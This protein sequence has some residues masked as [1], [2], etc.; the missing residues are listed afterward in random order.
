MDTA[1]RDKLQRTIALLGEEK[2]AKVFNASVMVIGCGA[3]GGYAL[4][5]IA[6]LGFGKIWAV[7][8]D[9][10]EASNINR[11]ILATT[12]T[13]GRQKCEVACE[14]VA[15]I[16][17]DAAGVALNMRIEPGQLDFIDEAKPDFVIDAIDDVPA[18]TA[19]AAFL[20]RKD[21]RFVSAMGAAL[22]TR[23]ELLRVAAL[24]KT[25]GCALAKKMRENL[26]REDVDLRRVRCVYSPEKVKICKDEAGNN[27]LGSLPMVPAAMGSLLAAEILRQVLA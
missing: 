23:P 16:N 19:L 2:A 7:D 20:V 18:K 1:L 9:V 4:E 12:E 13:I 27:I 25:E 5:M 21:I 22:K 3:V 24:D 11:Q 14:R 6:R 8:F 10:F 17:P 15:A 26:R